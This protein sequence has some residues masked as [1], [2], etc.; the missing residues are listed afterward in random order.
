MANINDNYLKLAGS[1]L[2]R[3]TAVFEDLTDFMNKPSVC[4]IN[5]EIEGMFS[6]AG[7]VFKTFK[8]C[9]KIHNEN[10]F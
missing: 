5:L 4:F 7:A 3:E 6:A 10:P 9:L 8:N 2:F 1:Y